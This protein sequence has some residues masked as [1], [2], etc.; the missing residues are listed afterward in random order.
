MLFGTISGLV[1][2]AVM[3]LLV[4]ASALFFN[5][6]RDYQQCARHALT[7]RPA[8]I[9]GSSWRTR[10]P[11][12]SARNPTQPRPLRRRATAL[13]APGPL[14]AASAGVPATA[15]PRNRSRRRSPLPRPRTAAVRSGSGPMSVR[16]PMP[17][18]PRASQARPAASSPAT[19]PTM[20]PSARVETAAVNQR[21]RIL[22]E[23]HSSKWFSP[24]RRNHQPARTPA[25]TGTT[26]ATKP[27]SS[28]PAGRA[29]NTGNGRQRPDGGA[30]RPGLRADAEG[31]ARAGDPGQREHGQVGQEAELRDG[32]HGA[33]HGAGVE[34][35]IDGDHEVPVDEEVDGEQRRGHRQARHQ[36]HEA[37]LDGGAQVGAGPARVLAGAGIQ[38]TASTPISR[39]QEP[40]SRRAPITMPSANGTSGQQGGGT[41]G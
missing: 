23:S 4:L 12:S 6:V 41:R 1:V 14:R 25:S 9:A 40:A 13:P 34:P 38:A 3:V 39:L 30:Q 28:D 15:R 36:R 31:E 21:A 24:S 29:A 27:K 2:S 18:E 7:S 37:G 22:M 19:A 16:R 35:F 8:P 10:C 32:E 26:R 33:A 5:Q 17:A 11:A 20:T